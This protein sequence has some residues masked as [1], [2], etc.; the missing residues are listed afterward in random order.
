MTLSEKLYD[1]A[2]DMSEG[3]CSHF[4]YYA[5]G[6]AYGFKAGNDYRD[7]IFSDKEEEAAESSSVD[8]AATKIGW[9]P[10][11]FKTFLLLMASEGV[12]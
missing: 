10:Q 11:E 12:K 8:T 3:T 1:V 6:D 5:V 2:C 9:T 4:S 7:A